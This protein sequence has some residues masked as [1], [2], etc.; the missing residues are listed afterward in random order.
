[1]AA[2]DEEVL[3]DGVVFEVAGFAFLCF[4]TFVAG[5][6][7]VE[8]V[9]LPDAAGAVEFCAIRAAAEIARAIMVFFIA[10]LLGG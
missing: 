7:F 3:P 5:A 6:G 4:L 8:F 10:S 9:P 2:L 1:L